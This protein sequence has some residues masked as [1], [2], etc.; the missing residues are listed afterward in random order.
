MYF[1]PC[2]WKKNWWIESC[3]YCAYP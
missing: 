1:F 3:W 2:R